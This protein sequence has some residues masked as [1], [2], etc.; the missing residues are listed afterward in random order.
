MIQQVLIGII[1][2][3]AVFYIFR[4]VFRNFNPSKDGCAKGCGCDTIETVS[5]AKLNKDLKNV[6]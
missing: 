6:R 2:L 4:M 5:K 3:G 1:F